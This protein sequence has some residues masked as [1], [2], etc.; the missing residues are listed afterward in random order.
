[1]IPLVSNLA[2][3]S[4]L[5]MIPISSIGTFSE[6]MVDISL[7]DELFLIPDRS[8]EAYHTIN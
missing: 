5:A 6:F 3:L 8:C 2:I 4:S 7:V 1:M